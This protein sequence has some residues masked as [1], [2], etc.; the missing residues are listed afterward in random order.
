MG[1]AFYGCH[2][3]GSAV[4]FTYMYLRESRQKLA[5]GTLTHLQLVESVWNPTKR[6]SEIRILFNCGRAG[7]PLVTERLRRLA[8]SIL[9]RC[10]P[11]EIIA[12]DS[13]WQLINA[14]PYGDAYVLQTLWEQLG[15]DQII[16]EQVAK[17]HF[18]F[19]MERALFAMVANRALAPSSK[20]YCTSSGCRKMFVWSGATRLSCSICTERWTFWKRTRMR[21]SRRFS[22]GYRTC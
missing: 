4:I 17:R 8:H 7:D 3:P 11:E 15:I 2:T 6:R 9:R 18:G 20:L 22:F 14:W 10:S 21:S 16:K 19:D 12:T 13:T 5:N 1:Y